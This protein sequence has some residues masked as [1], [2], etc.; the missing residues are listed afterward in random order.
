MRTCFALFLMLAADNPFDGSWSTTLSCDDTAKSSGYTYEF[1]SVVK[2]GELHGEKGKQGKP[3]WLLIEGTIDADGSAKLT[4]DGA[5][6]SS[7]AAAG[8]DPGTEYR[9]KVDAKFTGTSASGKRT[10]GRACTVEFARKK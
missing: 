6:G 7:G 3:G 8:R 5:V 1:K 10:S 2:D 9:Y 4:V